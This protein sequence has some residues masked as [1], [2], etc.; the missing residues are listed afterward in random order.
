MKNMPE[1]SHYMK[2]LLKSEFPQFS[3]LSP[4]E[5]ISELRKRDVHVTKMDLSYFD[6]KG[7]IR[8]CLRLKRPLSP[9]Q[10]EKYLSL[11]L[12]NP[13]YWK[14]LYK[15]KYIEFP[16][17]N[18]SKTRYSYSNENKE[19]TWIY[20]HPLQ[21]LFVKN[22]TFEEITKIKRRSFLYK[23]F[24]LQTLAEQEKKSQRKWLKIMK[25]KSLNEYNRI[26]GL[27]MV[28]EERYR[29]DVTSEFYQKPDDKTFITKWKKWVRKYP[30]KNILRK[31]MWNIISLKAEYEHMVFGT[32]QLD[33]INKWNPFPEIIKRGKRRKLKGKALLA[34]DFFEAL[35]TLS[36][37][38]KDLTGNS[39]PSPYD[40]GQWNTGWKEM[41]YGE[42]YD[43]KSEKTINRILSDFLTKR[44]IICSIIYEGETEDR[45]IR[46]IMKSVDVYDPEKQG[47][48]LYNTEGSGN[49]NQ[50]NLDGYIMRANLAE[51][52]V[53]VIIDKDAEKLLKKHLDNDNIKH[54]NCIIWNNDFEVDNFGIDIVIEKINS[55]LIKNGNN[56]ITTNEVKKEM[57]QKAL[58]NAISS[59]VY[60]N[61]RIELTKLITK[62]ELAMGILDPRI[63]NIRKEYNDKGWVPV[64]PIEKELKR[65]LCTI[66]QYLGN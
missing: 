2:L 42:P 26:I 64:Y 40:S 65:I 18:D 36:L 5:F 45:V 61:Q 66:P 20:Y 11:M 35:Q 1:I 3:L 32:N 34:Q 4:K 48:H 28:L 46:A 16:E 44:P 14:E 60:K 43:V 7:I 6:K 56:S 29:P 39:M 30:A 62:P 17:T 58:F 49:M 21:M 33:P 52:D 24:D 53:Y 55:V 63:K 54:E 8:P 23:N 22:Q 13:H 9:Y 59:V 51:N 47:I 41:V 15:E 57:K 37:F 27:L 50:K 12:R 31:S 38:I 19:K 10:N 25:E